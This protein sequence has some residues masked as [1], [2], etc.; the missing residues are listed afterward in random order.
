[1]SPESTSLI[2]EQPPTKA[3]HDNKAAKEERPLTTEPPTCAQ[4]ERL[5]QEAHMS[6]E[7]LADEIDVEPRSVYRHLSGETLPH[8]KYLAAYER[9][10]LSDCKDG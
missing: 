4:I 9:V 2:D 3:R 7:E 5:R 10:F 8:P 1:M 6:V